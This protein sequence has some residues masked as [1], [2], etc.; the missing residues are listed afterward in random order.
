MEIA[1]FIILVVII[2]VLATAL[3]L[4]GGSVFG[5]PRGEADTVSPDFWS[6]TV[7]PQVLCASPNCVS[8]IRASVTTSQAGARGQVNVLMP[9]NRVKILA[10]GLVVNEDLAGNAP[11]FDAGF[12]QHVV[13]FEASGLVQGTVTGTSDIYLI[14]DAYLFSHIARHRFS[15][16]SVPEDRRQH[17]DVFALGDFQG[18]KAAR[19]VSFCKS[20]SLVEVRCLSIDTPAGRPKDLA[21]QVFDASGALVT[22][23]V[24]TED[25]RLAVPVGRVRDVG[26]V[27]STLPGGPA[28]P[29]LPETSVSWILQF[30]FACD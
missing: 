18:Q 23:A 7:E 17:I 10:E 16:G 25:S 19:T 30:R 13:T 1:G 28:G 12:G 24:L 3:I 9:D 11:F 6:F 26:A 21:V 29:F 15:I 5:R 14:D 4:W 27:I 20:I 22:G 8:E 2:V